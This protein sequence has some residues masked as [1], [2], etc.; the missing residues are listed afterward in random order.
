MSFN[1]GGLIHRQARMALRKAQQSPLVH[2]IWI[3][4]RMTKKKGLVFAYSCR[5]SDLPTNQTEMSKNITS[6]VEVTPP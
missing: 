4:N 5:Q 1:L 6:L 2:Q 3:F